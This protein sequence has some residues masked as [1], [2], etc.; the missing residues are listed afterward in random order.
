MKKSLICTVLTI[1]LLWGSLIAYAP[2]AAQASEPPP[3]ANINQTVTPAEPVT[4]VDVSPAD[5][6][7]RHVAY[8][9]RFG[10]IEGI[11]GGRFEPDRNVTR[12][13]FITMLG[14]LH[15]YGNETIGT[16][17]VGAYYTRY[18]DWAVEMGI[19]KGNEH[20]DLMPNAYITREQMAVIVHRY[21]SIYEL[22]EYFKSDFGVIA[23]PFRDNESYWA[24]VPI[25]IL[26]LHI[27]VSSERG[28]FFR[29]LDNASRAEALDILVRICSA[30]YDRKH[31]LQYL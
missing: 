16:P 7:Y 9:L 20:G 29:P 22:W 24:S 5:W 10:L 21:I 8:G 25:E 13:E 12:A 27:L 2:V 28:N 23:M 6:F 18:L 15:E 1:I 4:M 17:D 14:R 26:R 3:A 31:P 30:V 11:D 19:I